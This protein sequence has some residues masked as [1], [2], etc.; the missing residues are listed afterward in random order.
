MSRGRPPYHGIDLALPVARA[1]GRVME[2]VQNGDTPA[3]FVIDAD[4]KIFFVYIRRVDPF[5]VTPAD[6]EAENRTVLTLIR[7]LPASA[8][9]IREFW[10]YSKYGTL[11]F[12]RVED[13]RLLAIGRDGRPLAEPVGKAVP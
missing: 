5:R 7:S 10:P 11:R 12:F 6:M 9:I 1:R 13:S 4:G 2:I 8:D 3:M